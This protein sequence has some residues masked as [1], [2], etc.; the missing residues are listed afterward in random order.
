MPIMIFPHSYIP[1][2]LAEKVYAFLGSLTIC[3]PWYMKI[4]V[5]LQ[6]GIVAENMRVLYPEAQLKPSDDFQRILAEYHGWVEQNRGK[7]FPE[8]MNIEKESEFETTTWGIRQIL[9][10]MPHTAQDKT[11]EE[12]LKWHLTLHL[13]KELEEIRI[14]TDIALKA[15]RHK[16][17]L[18]EGSV[19]E[20][21]DIKVLLGDLPLF[22]SDHEFQD[23][24]IKQIL[25]A[26][27][28]LFGEYLP[29]YTHLI[30]MNKQIMDY[31]S[32]QWDDLLNEESIKPPV[33]HITI[34][35]ISLSPSDEQSKMNKELK[36]IRDLIFG[37][38][39]KSFEGLTELDE[40]SNN[41]NNQ[42]S[43]DLSDQLFTITLKHFYTASDGQTSQDQSFLPSLSNKTLMLIQ[44]DSHNG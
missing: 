40:L 41:L 14:E 10:Q 12:T 39:K 1:E 33:I 35:D 42:P 26:W 20:A 2:S 6:N 17:P 8:M 15:L 19:E 9:K 13:A 27:F 31:V 30:T 23:I 24:R 21:E 34:P 29:E 43:Q 37:L 25:D 22:G 5:S 36:K 3:L 18:L 4:P 44:E 16:N 7:H 28:G 38:S 11:G 32:E